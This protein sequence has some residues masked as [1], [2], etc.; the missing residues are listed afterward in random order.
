M[1]A[2]L[3]NRGYS[4]IEMVLV[5]IFLGVALISTMEMM[6]SGLVH[7]LDNEVLTTAINLANDKMETIFADKNGKGFGYIDES[8]YAAETNANGYRGFSRYV[9][10][11]DQATYK[12]VK[13]RVTHPNIED[14]IL[15]AY[16]ANY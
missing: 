16:L 8:N 1:K 14:C 5:I 7:N 15:T 11:T 10:V 6:S 9:T 3:N 13:V 2:I 12:E 4:L